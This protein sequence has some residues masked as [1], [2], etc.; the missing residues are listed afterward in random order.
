M[1]S[2]AQNTNIV[3]RVR[4]D[5]AVTIKLQRDPFGELLPNKQAPCGSGHI[6]HLCNQRAYFWYRSLSYICYCLA[7]LFTARDIGF[8]I[9]F[10]SLD[11]LLWRILLPSRVYNTVLSNRRKHTKS[12][13]ISVLTSSLLCHQRIKSQRL[14][15]RRPFSVVSHHKRLGST[16]Y[17]SQARFA[18]VPT[19][20]IIAGIID[21]ILG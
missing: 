3:Y 9:W 10:T 20:R 13:T 7:S 21:D 18:I 6:L 12:F 19:N 2:T 17:D 8:R 1:L 16:S 4:E 11:S 14:A 5:G 15:R